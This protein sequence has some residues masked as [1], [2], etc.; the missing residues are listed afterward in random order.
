MLLVQA[1]PHHADVALFA[2]LVPNLQLMLLEDV[3]QSPRQLRVEIQVEQ[4]RLGLLLFHDLGKGGDVSEE[5]LKDLAG[6]DTVSKDE[7]A[8]LKKKWLEEM[9]A[10]MKNNEKEEK[11]HAKSTQE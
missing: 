2:L 7:L 11:D 3:H 9:K 1:R 10:N 4:M 6:K 5:E 8:D